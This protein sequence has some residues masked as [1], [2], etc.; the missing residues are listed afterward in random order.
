[1]WQGPSINFLSSGL[2]LDF[3]GG[4]SRAW[5]CSGLYCCCY[6]GRASRDVRKQWVK[7][8]FQEIVY[9]LQDRLQHVPV[10]Q[11]ATLLQV[12]ALHVLAFGTALN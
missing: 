3:F 4:M 9:Q 1:M 10:E 7:R 11:L 12:F 6:V 5:H 2:F 8:E